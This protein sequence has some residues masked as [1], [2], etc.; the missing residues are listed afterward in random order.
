MAIFKPRRLDETGYLNL[1]DQESEYR[2][3][4][5]IPSVESS[6]IL[7]YQ[8]SREKRAPAKDNEEYTVKLGA[9]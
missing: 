3:E 4:G 5:R 9:N 6:G 1:E 2:Q 8:D 7:I